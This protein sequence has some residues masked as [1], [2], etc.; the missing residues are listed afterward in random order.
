MR[1]AVRQLVVSSALQILLESLPVS[2]SGHVK[3]HADLLA[4]S[5]TH[6]NLVYLSNWF[7]QWINFLHVFTVVCSLFFFRKILFACMR[8]P[9]DY[10]KQ[11]C[12]V[13]FFTVCADIITVLFFVFFKMVPCCMIPLPVGFFI[14]ICLL[15]SLVWC[16]KNNQNSIS[17][18]SALPLGFVQGLAL[19]P[20]IS[21]YASVYVVS[22]WLGFDAH[23]SFCIAWMLQVPLIVGA[24][25][26]SILFF[27]KDP[28]LFPAIDVWFACTLIGATVGAYGLLLVSYRL[29]LRNQW[30][31]FGLYMIFPFIISV[32]LCFF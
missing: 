11:I 32:W 6:F 30:W 24:L 22:R 16:P 10:A 19:M 26:K 12:V 29:A 13:I 18:W 14:T 31:A 28:H 25:G 23:Y 8:A 5:D 20:G 27:Y 7:E 17:T 9:F 1:L 4:I 2:S 21:R 3:L 15:F